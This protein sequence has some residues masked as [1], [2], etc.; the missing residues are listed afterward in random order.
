MFVFVLCGSVHAADF[1]LYNGKVLTADASF[2]LAEA[3]AIRDGKIL[4]VG[5]NAE[6]LRHAT[7]ETRRVDLKGKTIIPGLIDT[8]AHLFEYPA[9]GRAGL[10]WREEFERVEPRMRQFRIIRVE[11]EAVQ[12]A[13]GKI[14]DRAKQAQPGHWL[15][16]V[17]QPESVALNIWRQMKI[18]ELDRLAPNNPLLVRLAGGQHYLNSRA[19]DALRKHYGDLPEDLEKDA[20]G[21]PTGR[22]ARGIG[23]RRRLV[24][25]LLSTSKTLAPV[26]KKEMEQWA[27]YG[28]TTWSS[29]LA[30][31]NP[32]KASVELDRRGEMPIRFAYSHAMGTVAFPQAARFYERLGDIAGHGTAY[33]WNIGVS[34]DGTDAPFPNLCTTISARPEVKAQEFCRAAPGALNREVV[35]AMV[36]AGLRLTGMNFHGDGALD[37]FMDIVEQASQE[38]GMT[39]EEIRARRHGVDHCTLGPRPDQIERGKRLG[40]IW[41]CGPRF[42]VRDAP[43]AAKDYGVKYAH[44]W[45]VPIKSI[46]S[47]GGKAVIGADDLRLPL[48]GAFWHI[49]K[50]VT[51]KDEEGNV[52]GKEQAVDRKAALLMFTRWAA[53]YVLRE[54]VLGSLE[55]GKWADLVVVDRDFLGVPDEEIHKI[56]VLLTAVGGKLVYTEPS[57]AQAQQLPQVGYRPK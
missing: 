16:L 34:T 21:Q 51:R 42:F 48:V 4:A 55:P 44:E 11:A 50:L 36:K 20:Q 9:F 52:W 26:F 22:V 8:H 14:G 56:K 3:V 5:G 7:A 28:I 47:A 13:L 57:F 43:R 45:S 30:D 35:R 2:S 53:E 24:M 17:I 32:F 37:H 25:D 54:D 1:I 19:L 12:D 6:I 49:E 46:L 39:L 18:S 27:S 41:S 33:L 40:I 38:T 10:G 29:T 23:L 31:L 15:H